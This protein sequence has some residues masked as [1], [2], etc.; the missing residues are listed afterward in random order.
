[1]RLVEIIPHKIFR[2][3]VYSQDLH[4]YVEIE[5]GP[6][7][8]C[9]RFS[10]EL[11]PADKGGVHALLDEQFLSRTREI[12]DSMHQNFKNAIQRQKA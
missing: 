5:G 10:K 3:S 11:A 6:M 1:M 2:I 9:F 4:Y 12:F 8:Q 7:K